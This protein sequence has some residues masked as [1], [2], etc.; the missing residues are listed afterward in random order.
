MAASKKG[1]SFGRER[2]LTRVGELPPAYHVPK[3]MYAWAI[4]KERHGRPKQAM[5]L[6][7]LPTPDIGEDEALVLVMAAGGEL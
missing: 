5:Q 4:R 2:P 6:E 7:V 3:N 1:Q